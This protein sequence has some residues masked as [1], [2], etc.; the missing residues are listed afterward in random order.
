M[1]LRVRAADHTRDG[2]RHLQVLRQVRLK[3]PHE[4]PLP[5]DDYAALMRGQAQLRHGRTARRTRRLSSLRG[6]DV[7]KLAGSR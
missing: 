5:L 7:G 3:G 1:V 6:C 2:L 4:A